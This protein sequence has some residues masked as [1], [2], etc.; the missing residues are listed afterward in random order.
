MKVDILVI[1]GG[2]GGHLFPA[3]ATL[4]E[5][6]ARGKKAALITDDRCEKYLE[7]YSNI[8]T[9]IIKQRRFEGI[10]SSI[11]AVFFSIIAMFQSYILLRKLKPKLIIGFGGYVIYTTLLV[12][13]WMRIPIMLHEQ[14]AV[15]GKA[16]KF[17]AKRASKL[18]LSFKDTKNIP[19]DLPKDKII[20]TG[21]P[22][23]AD[24]RNASKKKGDN[25]RIL[26]I[27]GSQGARFLSDVIPDAINQVLKNFPKKNIEIIQ[28]ARMEDIDR[29]K[30][31]YAEYNIKAQISDFFHNM[32]EILKE[33]DLIISRAGAATITEIIATATPSI[34]L[35]YP[36]ASE[37]HQ[38][39]NAEIIQKN[40][41]GIM[42]DQNDATIVSLASKV[43]DLINNPN[44]LLDMSKN[45][46][47]LQKDSAHII[48]DTAEKIIPFYQKKT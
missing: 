41:C 37:M 31:L 20:V 42:L 23:R 6:E 9:Y 7:N 40:N 35:P 48:V 12:A 22:V 4:E 13:N 15:M 38:H 8:N 26:I 47:K 2:T 39:Y 19:E 32:P 36:Y 16:N 28:Q 33:T 34:L 21:N 3:I 5:F 27:G 24:I 45:L 10:L 11:K 14:N 25:F 17:F 29:V 30:S 46:K 44:Q 1:G 18:F 43:S